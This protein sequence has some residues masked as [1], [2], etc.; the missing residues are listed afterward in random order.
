MSNNTLEKM[1]QAI[2]YFNK[3]ALKTHN[4]KKQAVAIGRTDF[5]VKAENV[6]KSINDLAELFLAQR[7]LVEARM[8][9]KGEV[10]PIPVNII[11]PKRHLMLVPKKG[12]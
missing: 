1:D 7:R 11:K 12:R 3:V 4:L 8:I 2:N 6:V 10:V 5:A 9:E